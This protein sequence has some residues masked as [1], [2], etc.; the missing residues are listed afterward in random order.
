MK[1]A[2]SYA[3]HHDA[4]VHRGVILP[5]MPDAL[6]CLYEHEE[7]NFH[8]EGFWAPRYWI[9]VPSGQRVLCFQQHGSLFT[10]HIRIADA[11]APDIELLRIQRQRKIGRNAAYEVLAA[12]SDARLGFL[13]RFVHQ[14]RRHCEIDLPDG[15]TTVEVIEDELAGMRTLLH[16]PAERR[17]AIFNGADMI[18]QVEQLFALSQVNTRL[19]FLDECSPV[20]MDRRLLLAAA[21][22]ITLV[23]G[24]PGGGG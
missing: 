13:S 11:N 3:V 19:K 23:E 15:L 9:T 8:Q 22:L 6:G 14:L 12:K 5:T 17:F 24:P 21:V 16:H 18:G 4:T 10:R 7:F 2:F 20:P 1:P